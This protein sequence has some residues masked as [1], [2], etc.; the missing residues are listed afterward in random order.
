MSDEKS[1]QNSGRVEIGQ[2]FGRV[3]VI[4]EAGN[5]PNGGRLVLCRCD[6]D[7]NEKVVRAGNLQYGGTQSCGCLQKESLSAI[8][9][10]HGLCQHPIYD[11][12]VGMRNRCQNPN[13]PA[14]R[15]YGAKGVCVA[16]RWD[17]FPNFLADMGERPSLEHTLDRYPNRDGNYE[18]GNVR[19]A[20][21]KEQQR[22]RRNNVTLE[23]NGH[24]KLLIEWAEEVG[25]SYTT[26]HF[27]LSKGWSPER[28]LTTPVHKNLPVEFNGQSKT[29]SAWARELG[30]TEQTLRGRFERGWSVEDAFLIPAGK[31]GSNQWGQQ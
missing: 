20:T 14:Y 6:C 21:W 4:A 19:W 12:W 8:A 2:R 29:V 28:A 30:I 1:T 22:N 31:V 13:S 9:T 24:V 18:P 11:I 3:V 26:L 16:D 5:A 7:G 23:F 27:R 17:Y 10:T 25:I 15:L